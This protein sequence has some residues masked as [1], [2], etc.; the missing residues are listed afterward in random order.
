[1]V[2][3][4]SPEIPTHMEEAAQS[5]MHGVSHSA[6]FAVCSNVI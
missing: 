1:M 3:N 6:C 2:E 5:T 4:P